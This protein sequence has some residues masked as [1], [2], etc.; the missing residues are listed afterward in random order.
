MSR[1]AFKR[2]ENEEGNILINHIFF[3]LDDSGSMN[4]LRKE[5]VDNLNETLQS[6]KLGAKSDQ[7]NLVSLVTFGHG[8]KTLRPPTPLGEFRELVLSDYNPNANTPLYDGIGYAIGQAELSFEKYKNFNN[9]ALLFILTDGQENAS[10][11]FTRE[12]VSERI[13]SLQAAGRFTFTFMGCSQEL[14]HQAQALGIYKANTIVWDYTPAGLGSVSVS[15]SLCTQSYFNA[16]S[17][18]ATACSGFYDHSGFIVPI[19]SGT[20]YCYPSQTT[21]A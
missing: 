7:A 11:E 10:R 17:E 2:P 18:G 19:T 5:T 3:V 13:K 4:W 20:K 9:A 1:E 14:V 6:L 12:K 8:V 21:N 15:N 16:R